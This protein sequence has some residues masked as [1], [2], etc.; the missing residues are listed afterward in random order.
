VL[1]LGC[2]LAFGIAVAPRVVLIL[3]W[4]FSDRWAVVWG[5]DFLVPALGIAFAPF[6]TVMYMLVWS[7][8]G[9]QGWDW[10]WI[11]LGVVLDI[12]HY[13]QMAANRK[14]VPGYPEQF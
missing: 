1:L 10:L 4:I 9:I 6:T 8:A 14:Q 2:L 11:L 12:G 5:G 7:P 13:G 3:A